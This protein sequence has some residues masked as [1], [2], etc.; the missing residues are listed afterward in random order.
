MREIV[1]PD[2]PSTHDTGQELPRTGIALTEKSLDWF[3]F[4]WLQTPLVTDIRTR[5]QKIYLWETQETIYRGKI[6]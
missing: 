1:T 6:V 4:N 5:V 2:V 3:D